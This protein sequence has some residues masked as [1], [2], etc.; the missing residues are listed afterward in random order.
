[1]NIKTFE[2]FSYFCKNEKCLK[3][4][5]ISKNCLKLYKQKKCYENFIKKLEKNLENTNKYIKDKE[6]KEKIIKR[7]K[8]CK[9][10]KVLTERER[11]FILKNFYNDYI[12]LSHDL[13]ICHIIPRS[14]AP[15]KIY[16]ENNVF[17]ASRY[18]HSLL[19]EYRHHVTKR[20]ISK[21][22]RLSWCKRI[23]KGK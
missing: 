9:V 17:L 10:W 21:E 20:M 23:L 4:S 15:D 16:D 5:L 7:D 14:Q 13:D 6:F 11:R 3:N 12:T 22:E 2:E 8:T 1:M 18:F 19:D